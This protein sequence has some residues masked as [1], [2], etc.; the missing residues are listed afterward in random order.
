MQRFAR[1]L[2]PV[3]IL[4]ALLLATASPAMA[5]HDKPVVTVGRLSVWASGGVTPDSWRHYVTV[6]VGGYNFTPGGDVYVTFQNLS[7]GTPAIDG[8][9]IK[10]GTGPCGLECNNYG[11]IS[12]SR[13]LNYEYGSVCGDLL[14]TWA[15]DAAKSPAAGYGW[16]YRDARVSC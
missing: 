5:T 11:R 10:A 15:W 6:P 2:A 4:G 14:R 8:E 3:A 16:S 9:W 7:A 13:T 12:Y 1:L